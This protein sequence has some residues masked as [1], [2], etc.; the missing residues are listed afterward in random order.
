MDISVVYI[1][2]GTFVLLTWAVVKA[3]T[4]NKSHILTGYEP[5]LALKRD[6]H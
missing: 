3:N 4:T 6:R 2:T 5:G 1:R